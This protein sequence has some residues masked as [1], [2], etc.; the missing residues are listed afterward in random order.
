MRLS[1]IG[2]TSIA[3]LKEGEVATMDM[4]PKDFGVKKSLSVDIKGTTPDDKR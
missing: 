4:K 2:K 3:W 1:T